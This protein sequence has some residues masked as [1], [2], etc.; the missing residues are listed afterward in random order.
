M[1]L[2]SH[3]SSHGITIDMIKLFS[4]DIKKLKL[5]FIARCLLWIQIEGKIA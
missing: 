4:H 3:T 2:L 5:L 1:K